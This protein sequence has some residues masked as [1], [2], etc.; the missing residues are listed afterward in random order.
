VYLRQQHHQVTVGAERH[1]A[2]HDSSPAR[3]NG[4]QQQKAT[5]RVRLLLWRRPKLAV[6]R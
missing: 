6:A 3:A 4:E 1:R 5:D 2:I